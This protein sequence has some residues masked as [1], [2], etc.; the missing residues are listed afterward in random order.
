MFASRR[1]LRSVSH[2]LPQSN[3]RILPKTNAV[4]HH[5]EWLVCRR[6]MSGAGDFWH[7]RGS[8]PVE[9]LNAV[10]RVFRGWSRPTLMLVGNHDQVL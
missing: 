8:L 1:I 6:V 4:L 2:I 7:A 10:L 9:P 5:H 3:L